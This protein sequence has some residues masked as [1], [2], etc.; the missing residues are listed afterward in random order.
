MNLKAKRDVR[1]RKGKKMNKKYKEEK[2]QM[3]ATEIQQQLIGSPGGLQHTA[4]EALAYPS[5]TVK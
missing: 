3:K 2:T 4:A 5:G 1:K